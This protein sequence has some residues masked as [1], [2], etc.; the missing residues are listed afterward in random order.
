MP[1][2]ESRSDY[3]RRAYSIVSW[4]YA[5]DGRSAQDAEVVRADNNPFAIPLKQNTI[6]KWF[7]D[8]AAAK[9]EVLSRCIGRNELAVIEICGT[10]A[11]G[12]Q[13]TSPGFDLC[14]F[15]TLPFEV[16]FIWSSVRRL[17]CDLGSRRHR[18]R[19]YTNRGHSPHCENLSARAPHNTARAD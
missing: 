13:N 6:G 2:L 8:T 9:D 4:R 5:S 14:P 1:L 11:D 3:C 10:V 7:F 16:D 18:R 15:A 17:T 12:K 19:G